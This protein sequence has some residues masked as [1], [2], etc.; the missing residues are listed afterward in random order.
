LARDYLAI[1]GSSAAVER[2]FSSAADICT[3]GR[4]GLAVRT[5]ERCVSSHMWLKQ[6]VQ[7]G[8]EFADAQ[9]F[10]NIC[11]SNSKFGGRKI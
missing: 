6:G 10:V 1:S 4:G 3:S 2:T 7:A 9:K 11:D 8:E 5:I